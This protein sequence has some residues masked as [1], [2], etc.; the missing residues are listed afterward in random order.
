MQSW[1]AASG[2]ALLL[3]LAPL[4]AQA[5]RSQGVQQWSG[6]GEPQTTEPI[7]VTNS[8]WTLSWSTQDRGS[9]PGY[10][11][12]DIFNMDTRM[13]AGSVSGDIGGAGGTAT[14]HT[15][16]GTFYLLINGVNTNWSVQ[17]FDLN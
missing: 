6:S 16:P 14:L 7:R 11:S 13:P 10:L 5:Q 17:V 12:I 2:L 15:G 8:D 4:G 1:L 3:A 9:I